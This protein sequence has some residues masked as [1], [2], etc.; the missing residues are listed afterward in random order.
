MR[1]TS[2]FIAG[3]L[4]LFL[5]SGTTARPQSESRPATPP[6]KQH[7]DL[8][9][10]LLMGVYTSDKAT[11]MYTMFRP[12][13][14]VL[15]RRLE[16]ELG[17][18]IPVRLKIVDGYQKALDDLIEG[19]VD[20]VRFGPA[21]YILA[22][23][24][25]PGIRLLAMEVVGG[26]K[27]FSGVIAVR[28]DSPFETLADLKGATF[29]FGNAN[30]TIGRYLAEA[31]MYRAGLLLSDLKSFEFLDRHDQVAKAVELGDFD[32][33]ALKIGT[34]QEFNAESIRL[35]MLDR[36]DN[37]TKPWIARAGLDERI[38]D[39]LRAALLECKDEK[40]LGKLRVTG[41]APA[42]DDDYDFVRRGMLD[43]ARFEGRDPETRAGSGDE[44]GSTPPRKGT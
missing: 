41:F 26:K 42:T 27:R 36:F 21:S 35:R 29:A 16:G 18:K 39:G 34:F 19:Q 30:S 38:V 7:K 15:E 4:G 2:R 8:P 23:R 13:S 10:Q 5:A 40:A 31:E 1:S 32:A 25:Q 12:I 17:Q 9:D 33:G 24:A 6:D 14:E 3:V 43:A 28:P 20:F 44:P 37:V 11:T 22:Q